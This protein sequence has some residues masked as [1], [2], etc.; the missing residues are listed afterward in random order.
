MVFEGLGYQ[1]SKQNNYIGLPSQAE[2]SPA[3][4]AKQDIIVCIL[5]VLGLFRF[6]CANQIDTQ[7]VYLNFKRFLTFLVQHE[8]AFCC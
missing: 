3:E 1:N 2:S 7:Q 5:Q 6:D 4:K 8:K